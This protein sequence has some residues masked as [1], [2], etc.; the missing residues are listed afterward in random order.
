MVVVVVVVV[1]VVG[2]AWEYSENIKTVTLNYRNCNYHAIFV[3][4]QIS[5]AGKSELRLSWN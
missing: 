2:L 3:R 1:V 5:L 4:R